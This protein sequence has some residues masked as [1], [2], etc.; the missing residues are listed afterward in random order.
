MQAE[1]LGPC[2]SRI[3]KL[4]KLNNQYPERLGSVLLIICPEGKQNLQPELCLNG[5]R[6]CSC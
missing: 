3:T 5:V 6:F 4:F 2:F 1:E